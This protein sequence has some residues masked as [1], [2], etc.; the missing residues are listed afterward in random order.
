M[1]HRCSSPAPGAGAQVRGTYIPPIETETG[2]G[3]QLQMK[4]VANTR[5]VA[6][7]LSDL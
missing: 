2:E 7:L 4:G 1:G 6:P 3:R 5:S